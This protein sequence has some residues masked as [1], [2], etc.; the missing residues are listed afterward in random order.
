MIYRLVLDGSLPAC[1][2]DLL[3]SRF[4]GVQV[5]SDA[6]HTVIECP[7]VDQ[8]ALRSLMTQVWDVGGTV[9]LLAAVTRTEGTHSHDDD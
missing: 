5:R 2:T 1:I 7:V 4:E 6:V 8:S 9:L 3:R